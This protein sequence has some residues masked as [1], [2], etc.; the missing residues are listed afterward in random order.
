MSKSL[1]ASPSAQLWW[2]S[3]LHIVNDGYIAGLA[4]LLPFIAADLDLSYTEAGLLKTA[5]QGAISATQIPAGLLSERL[6]EMLVL[7]LGTAWFSLSHVALILAG[8][9]SVV[10]VLI[11]L[12]GVGGGVYHPVGTG[13]ISSVYPVDKSGPAIG[14][15]NFFGDVGKVG[16]PAL[17][18]VLVVYVG[19]RGCAAILGGMGTVSALLYLFHF[20]RDIERR[21]R[22]ISAARRSARARESDGRTSGW[23]IRRPRQFALYSMVG[24]VDTAIRSGVVA[25]LGF[26]LISAG[27]E[28]GEIGWLFSLTLFGGAFGK[29]LCGMPMQKWG[30]VKIILLT[31]VLMVLGCWALPTIQAG[32]AMVVFLP[33]FGFVLNGTSSV[34]YIGLV[35]TFDRGRH[36]RGY[37]LYYTSN[38]IAGAAAPYLFGLVGDAY[39]LAA[40]YYAAGVLML[41]GLPLVFFL[42]DPPSVSPS[43]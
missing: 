19:W 23:G 36:S 26:T 25:F 11:I 27:V 35:P 20:R 37:A 6:G 13:L 9:Y 40:V 3:L 32:W 28:Q 17:A 18:G 31:E 33:L 14:T 34:I 29:L 16:F 24:F 38:F 39:G 15:L 8:G 4:L 2:C 43:A 10:L 1:R 21:W 42:R 12:S 41:G 22:Q 5:M 30:A 7:G